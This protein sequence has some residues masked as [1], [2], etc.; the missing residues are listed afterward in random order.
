[1]GKFD[2]MPLLRYNCFQTLENLLSYDDYVFIIYYA[3]GTKESHGLK[4]MNHKVD[5]CG[6][7]LFKHDERALIRSLVMSGNME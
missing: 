1:M 5:P 4:L 6:Q 3:E 2:K 7:H